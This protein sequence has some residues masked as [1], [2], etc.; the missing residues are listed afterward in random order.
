MRAQCCICSE[1]FVNNETN[2]AATPCGHVFHEH[3]LARWLNSSKTCPS[4]RK[5]VVERAVIPKLFFDVADEES[6]EVDP[7]KL[8]NE[9]QTLRTRV[10][11]LNQHKAK[12]KEKVQ[13]L[14]DKLNKKQDELETIS[15]LLRREQETGSAQ[16]RMLEHFE[17]QQKMHKEERAEFVHTKRKLTELKHVDLLIT[18]SV[19]DC[20]ELMQ[21][22]SGGDRSSV[23]QLVK[24][25]AILKREYNQTKVE[26][27]TLKE[28]LD[29]YKKSSY[30]AT[31]DLVE[32][33][34]GY[35]ALQEQLS[36][37]EDDLKQAEKTNAA[38][39][40]K[41]SK[42]QYARKHPAETSGS[43]L[44]TPKAHNLS[45]NAFPQTPKLP[46]NGGGETSAESFVTPKMSKPSGSTSLDLG[47]DRM[48]MGLDDDGALN[49][50]FDL[51]EESP[52]TQVRKTCEEN[53]MKVVKISTAATAS[54]ATK[55]VRTDADQANSFPLSTLN[56]MKKRDKAGQLLGSTVIRK[57]Y[58]GFG[59]TSSFTQPLGPPKFGAF[60]ATSKAKRT[61]QT[62]KK[63]KNPSLPTL[64]G[65]VDLTNN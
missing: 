52:Q 54:R 22:Y 33:K 16:Q 64:D 23:Q 4:C 20:E 41:L 57:D 47:C 24:Y 40:A 29:T 31:R 30:A 3:C 9:L 26:K 60:K 37:S 2:I 32:M 48:L 13:E 6:E 51:F 28:Q 45:D 34:A 62:W 19:E 36:R 39:K 12:Q 8:S 15:V 38:L 59:G 11:E 5:N 18:G 46:L 63:M 43:F 50:S 14:R 27:R 55:R 1:L 21:Q 7:E 44:E 58:N 49:Q 17:M 42:L 65:F 10:T 56:I 25:A 61:A 35:R 53:N